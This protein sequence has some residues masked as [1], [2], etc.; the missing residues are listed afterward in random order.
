MPRTASRLMPLVLVLVWAGCSREKTKETSSAAAPPRQF[1]VRVLVVDDPGMAQAIENLAAE[2][3]AR[4][5]GKLSLAQGTISALGEAD[6]LASRPDAVIYPSAAIGT[7]MTRKALAPLPP[8]FAR[9]GELAWSDTFELLQVAETAWGQSTVAIPFGSPVL[10][11]YYRTDLFERFHKKPPQTWDEY[12][13]LAKF[14]SLRENLGDAVPPADGPWFGAVEPTAAHWGG[15]VLLARAAAY[16]K[17]RN[18][19]SALFKVDGLE[20]LIAGEPFVRALDEM[21]AIARMNPQ[22]GA[23]DGEQA[24]REFLSGHAAMVLALPGHAGTGKAPADAAPVATGFAELPGSSKV[25]DFANQRWQTRLPDENPHVTM[26]GLA[27]RLGSVTVSATEPRGAFQLLAWLSGRE[28][29]ATVSSASPATTLYRRSQVRTAQ[30]WLDPQTD[31]AAARQ[32]GE[33]VQQ[34]L[35]RQAYLFA[36]RIPGHD[37]YLAALDRAV[38]RAT[39]GAQSSA[40]ALAAAAETWRQITAQ[41]GAE[42][43]Q[44][45]YR[46]SLLLEP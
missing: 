43:Q 28:W 20:P 7:L 24:R 12:Q 44:Q 16:A 39:S 14:F 21:V 8:E 26:L 13:E 22:G 25:Y 41:N 40:A 10:T 17:H 35:G 18:H 38:E 31:G 42:T 3:Q 37:A 4:S 46:Q 9:H 29:G 23:L 45:A 34:A 27:G 2:W 15:R 6:S 32:Y 36:P 11:C 5:G 33:M 1:T 30:P 19:Y